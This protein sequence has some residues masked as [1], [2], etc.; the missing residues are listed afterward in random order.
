MSEV[1]IITVEEKDSDSRL[2]RWFHRYYPQLSHGTL[3]KMLR[4]KNI[5]VNN[6]KAKADLR[7]KAG[8]LIRVPPMPTQEE[9]KEHSLS[10]KDIDFIKSLVLYQDK[11]MIALNKPAGLAVQGGSK[12][13]RH[14]DGMLAA[15]ETNK[16]RPRLVHRL[17]KETA[18]VLIIARTVKSAAYLTKTFADKQTHKIY[19]ALVHNCPEKMQGIIEK[20]LLKKANPNANEQVVVDEQNGQ[21]AKTV[22]EVVDTT[23]NFSWIRLMP[24]TGRTHQLRVHLASIGC[25]I[26]GDEKYKGNYVDGLEKKMY[27]LAKA[28]RIPLPNGK[29]LKI[30]APTP[31]YMK[32]SF[33]F[34]KFNDKKEQEE[35]NLLDVIGDL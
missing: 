32:K 1:K 6:A 12:T 9:K 25:P 27:L 29:F 33:A 5:K 31:D 21:Y 26:I 15:F 3:E 7:L 30:D 34:F 28:I 10:Q 18:G 35:F 20:P 8:D 24:L 13:T 14:I 2:D 23:G 19:W 22:Y 4:G 11:D 17:D 16:E